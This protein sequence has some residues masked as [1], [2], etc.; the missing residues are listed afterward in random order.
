MKAQRS[1]FYVGSMSLGCYNDMR[2]AI[3]PHGIAG[4]NTCQ[5][6]VDGGINAEQP[7]CKCVCIGRLVVGGTGS[8]SYVT[9]AIKFPLHPSTA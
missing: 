2:C 7:A 4:D 8:L 1:W 5:C 9:V 6:I 3:P